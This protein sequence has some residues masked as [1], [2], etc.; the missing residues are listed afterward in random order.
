M[1]IMTISKQWAASGTGLQGSVG[2]RHPGLNGGWLWGWFWTRTYDFS[3]FPRRDSYEL[4]LSLH[5]GQYPSA[6]CL[7][8]DCYWTWGHRSVPDMLSTLTA[9]LSFA[10]WFYLL[11][12]IYVLNILSIHQRPNSYSELNMIPRDW[13]SFLLQYV[14][15]K[16]KW[17]SKETSG[18]I[19]QNSVIYTD[20]KRPI[21]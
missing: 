10:S 9:F 19:R 1:G 20:K 6:L 7:L 17:S 4:P 15:T 8:S 21:R 3:H 18:L 5:A 16:Q 14:Y 13:Q 12:C 11:L 2:G